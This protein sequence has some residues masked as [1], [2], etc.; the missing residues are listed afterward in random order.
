LWTASVEFFDD[1]RFGPNVVEQVGRV[2]RNLRNR[3]RF[4]ISNLD[5]L[6]ANDLVAREA[7][8]PLDRLACSV[9]DAFAVSVQACYARFDIHDAYLQAIEFESAMSGLYF[10]AMKDP[11]YSLGAASVR[12]RSVQSALSY[13]LTRFLVALAPI[14]SFTTEEAWQ[15]LPEALR[16]DAESVFDLS[17]GAPP[18]NVERRQADT[19]LW[20]RLRELRAQ[21]AASE[22]PRDF[23][24]RVTLKAPAGL[25][26]PLAALGDTLREALVVSQL[27]LQKSAGQEAIVEIL[28]AFGEKCR[29][30]WKFRELGADPAHPTIC[31]E[32]A[33]VVN[34]LG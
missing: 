23:E 6:S 2:Y 15:S 21:V 10:D 11:L 29:R 20:E 26:E 24:A 33:A 19:A 17:L 31:A 1:V 8:E 25:Y 22:S 7:M 9:A 14:L 4:M 32:C 30:C 27:D 34:A 16:G 18:E 13:V 28:P 5:D 3:I 12:R